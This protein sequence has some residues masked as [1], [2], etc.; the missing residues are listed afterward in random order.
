[1]KMQRTYRN[2]LAV[3]ATVILL[4][5]VL[6]GCA[7][8]DEPRR[9]TFATW[10]QSDPIPQPRLSQVPVQHT[11]A[12]A[13]GGEISETEREALAIFLRRN[14]IAPGSRV[15]LSAALPADGNAEAL[16]RRLAAVRAELASLGL[17]AATLPPGTG[18]GT[19]LP[20]GSVMVTAHVLAAVAP[21]C[22]GYNAPIE[23]DLEHRP[24]I[25]PGCS[26]AANLSLMLANPADLQTGQ[27]L[28]PADGEATTPAIQRYRADKVWPDSPP[29]SQVPFTTDTT[30][31]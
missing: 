1:M 15:T 28:A 3:A 8:T 19:Q 7:E 25:S 20:P 23:L 18:A 24:I 30:T 21:P 27:P 13:P 31:D 6:A 22:P 12:V 14:G 2:R 4:P 11:V 26:N 29:P 10:K 17:S 5:L 16:G 9:I